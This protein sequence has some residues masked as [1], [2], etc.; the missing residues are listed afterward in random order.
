MTAPLDGPNG[1]VGDRVHQLPAVTH[2]ARRHSRT[3]LWPL[4]AVTRQLYG[5]LGV[6]FVDTLDA[7]GVVEV[8]RRVAVTRVFALFP[9]PAPTPPHRAADAAVVVLADAIA[10]TLG[11]DGDVTVHRARGLDPR[12]RVPLWRRLYACT[13]SDRAARFAWPIAPFLEPDAAAR[14]WARA[15]LNRAAGTSPA[16]VISPFS[17][18]DKNALT[19][20][21]WLRLASMFDGAVL[22]PVYGDREVRRA[23]RLFTGVSNVQIV[24]ADLAQAAAL[25]ADPRG[26]VLG[27]DGGRMMVLAA[28]S[29][30]GALAVFGRWPA[31]AWALPNMVVRDKQLTPDEALLLTP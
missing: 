17:G 18:G 10:G 6:E 3:L 7:A 4:D 15:A 21:W 20:P 27:I 11:A 23:R 19:G 2:V 14:D 8:A 5:H 28:A 1:L 22:V 13:D 16:L 9:D 24:I 26:H 31:S 12:G 29:S 30:R 25:A